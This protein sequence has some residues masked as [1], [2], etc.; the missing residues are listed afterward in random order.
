MLI[1]G[2]LAR[3][4]KFLVVN[5]KTGRL[6]QAKYTLFRGKNTRFQYLL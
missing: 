2:R 1:G 6:E 4:V 3:N 5:F